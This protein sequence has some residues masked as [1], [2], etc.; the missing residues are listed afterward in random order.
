MGDKGAESNSQVA[1]SQVA[2]S[3][4]ALSQSQA[5]PERT[6]HHSLHPTP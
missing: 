6:T 5:K 4:V 1:L 2:L 3:Q